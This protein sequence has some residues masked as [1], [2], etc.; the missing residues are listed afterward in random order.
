M[1]APV[2]HRS[3]GQTLLV[4]VCDLEPGRVQTLLPLPLTAADDQAFIYIV[5][6]TLNSESQPLRDRS[7]L[8][9]N[10]ALPCH[11]P[12]GEG[13]WF[14]RAYFPSKELVRHA[15]LSGWTGVAAEVQVG[16]VPSAIRRFMWPPSV[17]VGG[18]VGRDG[19]REIELTLEVGAAV[20]LGSTPL[21]KFN[22]VYGVRRIG[23]RR[24]VTLERHLQDVMH[25][26]HVGVAHLKLA[27]DAAAVLGPATVSA[28]YLVEFGIDLGGS[29]LLSA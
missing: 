19:R 16:R 24:D 9:A 20:E 21:R 7:F 18:W 12:A 6:S 8:E 1:S 17:P 10:I 2:S 23:G 26:V 15:Y 5:W 25:R 22:R 28:G 4:A 11:G 29:E 3:A 27:G 13:T 14:A